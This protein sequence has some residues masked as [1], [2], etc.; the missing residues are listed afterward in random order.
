MTYLH[1]AAWLGNKDVISS[2]LL[3]GADAKLSTRLGMIPLDFSC[4]RGHKEAIDTFLSHS[5]ASFSKEDKEKI[6]EIRSNMSP[7]GAVSVIGCLAMG[8]KTSIP[9]LLDK[10]VEIGERTNTRN[11]YGVSTLHLAA[12]H[13]NKDILVSLIEKGAPLD[14]VTHDEGCTPLHFA[15][16]N[17]HKDIVEI[18]IQKGSQPNEASAYNWIPLDFAA[19]YG[20]KDVV[21]F[22]IQTA[23]DT[24]D[25]IPNSLS[26]GSLVSEVIE[27]LLQLGKRDTRHALL[28]KAARNGDLKLT[29]VLIFLGGKINPRPE[30]NETE[31]E[32]EDELE[33]YEDDSEDERKR[34]SDDDDYESENDDSEDEN[35]DEYETLLDEEDERNEDDENDEP[36]SWVAPLVFAA[37]YGHAAI[38]KILSDSGADLDIS[39]PA[40]PLH[41]ASKFGHVEVVELLIGMGAKVDEQSE[42][43]LSA[44][45]SAAFAGQVSAIQTLVDK[46][47]DLELS[48]KKFGTP[49]LYAAKGNQLDAVKELL[50]QGAEV[51]VT[52][53][54]T[55]PWT[56][57]HFAAQHG[58]IEMLEILKQH[59]CDE[60]T[61]AENPI[62]PLA[63]AIENGRGEMVEKLLE[64]GA[65][66]E[67]CMHL[68]ALRGWQD[69]VQKLIIHGVNIEEEHKGEGDTPLAYAVVGGD[70][71]TVEI[72]IK[73][74]AEI[75]TC[76]ATAFFADIPSPFLH[77]VANGNTKMVEYL[78]DNGLEL[79]NS[80]ESYMVSPLNCAAYAGV[81]E[82]VKLLLDRG[83]K[84]NAYD[85]CDNVLRGNN[86]ESGADVIRLL[87]KNFEGINKVERGCSLL[88]RAIM[89][90][91]VEVVEALIEC[92]A[93]IRMK[94][95]ERNCIN[96]AVPCHPK[97]IQLLL[98]SGAKDDYNKKKEDPALYK[99]MHRGDAESVKLLYPL[100]DW[101][102]CIFLLLSYFMLIF[103]DQEKR[104]GK[105]NPLCC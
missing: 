68:A 95:Q 37:R 21:E 10:L 100:F 47:A 63:I 1:I 75:N 98:D 38:I 23:I 91:Q 88:H 102:I 83:A 31:E 16:K 11:T 45:H 69:L 49:L 26:S 87:G 34:D 33:K 29:E 79:S 60:E 43:G 92:G 67:Y 24:H 62:Y 54:R 2:L 15:A 96:I 99:A 104:T 32:S 70:V 61:Y 20:H 53:S 4:W 27:E 25:N 39:S 76:V 72:L 71:G 42:L 17:G 3:S 30:A 86:P 12:K 6:L 74:G 55:V 80:Y 35:E 41:F 90:K 8:N 50:K 7:E 94:S 85:M 64:I 52:N 56:P 73:A 40:T 59:K 103:N 19:T 93:D 77:A 28:S 5:S 36:N 97:L 105:C 57:L 101:Y 18:L 14:C 65:N 84:P 78:L 51:N 44:L 58:N 82:M 22:M 9:D 46:G 48:S 66:T 13:G 81:P 89:K